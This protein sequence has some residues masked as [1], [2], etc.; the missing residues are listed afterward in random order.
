[1]FKKVLIANRGEIAVRVIR[2]CRELGIGA[3]AVYSQADRRAL[4][5]RLADEAYDLGATVA[6]SYLSATRLIEA[7]RQSNADA[8][9]PGY[10]FLSENADFAE[11]CARNGIGFIGPNPKA[12]RIMGNKT[13][14]RAAVAAMNVPLVPGMQENLVD[15]SHCRQWAERIGFPLMLKAAA[16]GGGKGMRKVD[17]PQDLAG[18]FRAARSEA[19]R[20]F[21]DDAMYMERYVEKPRHVEIQVLGDM[22][23]N[24]IHLGERECSIQ[25][26]HQKIIEEAPSP[27]V[28][29]EMRQRM[30]EA[31]ISAAR[32]VGYDSAGTV[33]FIVSGQTREFFFLEMNTRLQVEHPVTEMITGIDLCQEMIRIAA[34]EHLSIRQEEVRIHGHA[35]ECR[36]SAED[37]DNQFLPAAGRITSLRIPGGPGVRDDSGI[38]PGF[39][40][41]T[42]FD[43][44]LA[45]LV[46]WGPDRQQAINRCRRALAE[47][48]IQGIPTTLP[49]H[50]RVM[51]NERFVR[52]DFDT[53]FIDTELVKAPADAAKAKMAIIAAALHAYRHER[54]RPDVGAGEKTAAGDP[55]K[56]SG[57]RRALGS[58]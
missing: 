23:G 39:E 58:R 45:K 33:E 14:S 48:A 37:P 2:A 53:T 47:Y 44:L 5:V 57:R 40:I 29:A 17:R 42:Q 11:M 3:V 4:H 1:M 31:A 35:I 7:A 41:T 54:K 20:A 9:H 27:I 56:L 32:A 38:Y 51:A 36:I 30:G 34:G 28:D 13:T 8:I 19:S 12:I 55:W 16:G 25:R 43:P 24:L 26:R 15:E 52:G 18:A 21:G 46:V 49:F 50:D 6:E 22:H 10:G